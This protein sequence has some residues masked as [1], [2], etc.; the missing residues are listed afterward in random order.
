MCV[1]VAVVVKGD[2]FAILNRLDAP[3]EAIGWLTVDRAGGWVR[4]DA[5]LGL[6]RSLND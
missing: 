3:W 6:G 4:S 2:L 1:L 5:L